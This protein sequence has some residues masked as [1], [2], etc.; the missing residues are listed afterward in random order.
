VL[1]TAAGRH[2]GT[3]GLAEAIADGVREGLA[4]RGE[5]VVRPCAEVSSVAG[6][7]AVVLGSG[8]YFGHWVQAA[9]EFLLRCA[10]ELWERP[11]WI[12]SS[13]PIARSGP[14]GFPAEGLVDVHEAFRLTDA[15]EH[16]VFGGRLD[17]GR[18]DLPERA[19][20]TALGG[21]TGDHRDLDAARAWGRDIAA[22]LV[23]G[24]AE[25]VTA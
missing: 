8:V 5:V 10:V 18:L 9:R 16:R 11:V 7:D 20:V 4:G 21:R 2:G 15:R 1:V 24:A 19:V 13:G 3:A 22:A 25:P 23:G 14:A 17:P 6:F 12:F